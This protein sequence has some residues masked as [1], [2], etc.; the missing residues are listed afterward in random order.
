[1][2][3]SCLLG[4]F[5]HNLHSLH[6]NHSKCSLAISTRLQWAISF[7]RFWIFLLVGS[8]T[9]CNCAYLEESPFVGALGRPLHTVDRR[10]GYNFS[11]INES[12]TMRILRRVVVSQLQEKN[13]SF[14]NCQQWHFKPSSE[15]FIY[16]RISKSLPAP[17]KFLESHSLWT[18]TGFTCLIISGISV[19]KS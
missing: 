1:M 4:N 18:I 8:G 3:T 2:A 7:E 9:Q 15:G 16:F 14:W 10:Y 11:Q 13:V 12:F 5:H 6:Q 17:L 19:T